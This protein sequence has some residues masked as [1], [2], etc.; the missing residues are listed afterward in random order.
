MLEQ[1]PDIDLIL[2][3]AN[4]LADPVRSV[5]MFWVDEGKRIP[6][7]LATVLTVLKG[8]PQPQFATALALSDTVLINFSDQLPAASTQTLTQQIQQVNPCC[9]V[10]CTHHGQVDLSS[11]LAKSSYLAT[12]LPELSALPH[13]HSHFHS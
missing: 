13:P 10:L 2:I 7:R 1:Y 3:E 11:I 6:A 4:G 9:Q 8:P 5:Q 12:R